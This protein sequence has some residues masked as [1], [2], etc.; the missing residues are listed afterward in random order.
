MRLHPG[1]KYN[2]EYMKN[3]FGDIFK[4][5][6]NLWLFMKSV[7]ILSFC[8][9]TLCSASYAQVKKVE[10]NVYGDFEVIVR[11][12]DDSYVSVD[13]SGE[14]IDTD[15]EGKTWYYSSGKVE[16]IGGTKFWYYPSG[17]IEQIGSARFYYDS[18]GRLEQGSRN[19]SDNGIVF[20]M[21]DR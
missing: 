9:I 15:I 12:N 17:K 1:E 5:F 8:A 2:R 6:L 16:Q 14:I 18:S 4:Q 13:Q 7:F 10:V 20:R 19:I 21:K 11:V 3:N